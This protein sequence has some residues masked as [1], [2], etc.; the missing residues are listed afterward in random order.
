MGVSGQIYQR[1]LQRQARLWLVV[2]QPARRDSQAVA[3][4][5][6]SLIQRHAGPRDAQHDARGD[7]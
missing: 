1:G 7:Q 4:Q 2:G 6:W 5:V 3:V